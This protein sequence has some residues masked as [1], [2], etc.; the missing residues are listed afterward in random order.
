[1]DSKA[2]QP[3]QGKNESSPIEPE[4]LQSAEPPVSEL[5]SGSKDLQQSDV[6]KPP[7][8]V[9]FWSALSGGRAHNF[10]V[11]VQ[12][13]ATLS[14]GIAA[15]TWFFTQENLEPSI[16]ITHELNYER[17]SDKYGYLRVQVAVKNV[18]LVP[19]ELNKGSAIIKV[20]LPLTENMKNAVNADYALERSETFPHQFDWQPADDEIKI[21]KFRKIS[22]GEVDYFIL[23]FQLHCTL[24]VIDVETTFIKSK[25]EGLYEFFFE[26]KDKNLGWVTRSLFTVPEINACKT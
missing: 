10:A 13:L 25:K 17:L 4:V 14:I 6:E 9:G 12:S 21:E 18:G 22:P 15:L 24:E 16:N 19:L 3:E 7:W 26:D 11:V 1:M 23:D 2:D 20:I 5:P 8:F